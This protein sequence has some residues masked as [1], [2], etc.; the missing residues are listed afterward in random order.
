MGRVFVLLIWGHCE[1]KIFFGVA[2]KI[3]ILLSWVW[4]LGSSELVAGELVLPESS[5]AI[6]PDPLFLDNGRGEGG[7]WGPFYGGTKHTEG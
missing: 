6:F 2:Y 5:M 1:I 7:P 4:R 3:S